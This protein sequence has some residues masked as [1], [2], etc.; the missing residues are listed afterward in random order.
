MLRVAVR[1]LLDSAQAALAES[2]RHAKIP[3]AVRA[4]MH[5][6]VE[7]DGHG[8]V[9]VHV[10][11][12][13]CMCMHMYSRS[14][15]VAG[16]VAALALDTAVVCGGVLEL[17]AR[18]VALDATRDLLRRVEYL[19]ECHGWGW[20]EGSTHDARPLAPRAVPAWCRRRS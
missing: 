19:R 15:L 3:R 6:Q 17:E 2:L 7:A 1:R 13:M 20:G 12:G 8:H 14:M 18:M 10:A 16:H 4:C 9:H 11:C 5:R